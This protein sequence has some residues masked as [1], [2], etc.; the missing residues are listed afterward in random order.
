[1]ESTVL[2]RNSCQ[3]NKLPWQLIWQWQLIWRKNHGGIDT[4]DYDNEQAVTE[5][6][7]CREPQMMKAVQKKMTRKTI[8][9][10]FELSTN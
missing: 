10:L 5:E 9:N 6:T 3:S 1:M 7:V 4:R 2:F 8:M